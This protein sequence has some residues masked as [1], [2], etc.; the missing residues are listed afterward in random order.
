MKNR[1]IRI[2]APL[3]FAFSLTGSLP[4]EE[5]IFEYDFSNLRPGPLLDQ[6]GWS[7]YYPGEDMESVSPLV[8]ESNQD[9]KVYV[10][11]S[12]LGTHLI[13]RGKKRVAVDLYAAQSFA[14]EFDL[15]ADGEAPVNAMMGIG[16]SAAFPP[17][18]GV[19]FSKLVL[20]Q[21]EFDGRIHPVFGPDGNPFNLNPGDWYRLRTEWTY[22]EALGAWVA[23]IALRNLS[24][25]EEEFTQM[26]F[27]PDG[28]QTTA[29]LGIFAPPSGSEFWNLM[30]LRTGT[31]G[32][33]VAN[34]KL[35]LP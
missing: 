20:R 12:E 21:Q 24:L 27:D 16:N 3:A 35:F 5:L 11:Q 6:D 15:C 28:K 18:V 2:L 23:S 34:F 8:E 10:G 1:F 19:L 14:F 29:P 13:S 9:P 26:F 30:A 31:P 25:D 17:T 32:G 33:K 4:A 7:D 22:V